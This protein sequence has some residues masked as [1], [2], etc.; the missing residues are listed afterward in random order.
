MCLTHPTLHTQRDIG[1]LSE[2]CEALESDREA[3]LAAVAEAAAASREAEAS[4]SSA[5][6]DV[7]AMWSCLSDVWEEAVELHSLLVVVADG[8]GGKV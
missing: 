5:A 2:R 8:D 1:P 3:L 4:A 7:D 6:S